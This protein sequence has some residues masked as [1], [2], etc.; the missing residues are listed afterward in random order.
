MSGDILLSFEFP[1]NVFGISISLA[2]ISDEA[3]L[4][5]A[6]RVHFDPA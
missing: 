6:L 1:F 2:R 5:F 4:S 3:E